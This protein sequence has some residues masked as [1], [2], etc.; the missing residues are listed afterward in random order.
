[1]SKL[2]ATI[3]NDNNVIEDINQN[4]EM[5][6]YGT[7]DVLRI[8]FKSLYISISGRNGSSEEEKNEI[9]KIKEEI[10]NIICVNKKATNSKWCE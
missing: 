1:M 5:Y 7:R 10:K 3:N 8:K 4:T 9:Y 6:E 2:N